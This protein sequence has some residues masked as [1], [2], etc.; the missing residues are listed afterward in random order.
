M[1]ITAYFKENS[2]DGL[3]YLAVFFLAAG[4]AGAFLAGLRQDE[5]DQPAERKA[6]WQAI[7]LGCLALLAGGWPFWIT[8]LP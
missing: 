3:R 8:G 4:G 1:N 6:A 2:M 7:G 5:G